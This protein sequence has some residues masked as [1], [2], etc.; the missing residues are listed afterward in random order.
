MSSRSSSNRNSNNNSNS[1]NQQNANF[2]SGNYSKNSPFFKNGKLLIIN[3]TD[4]KWKAVILN[5]PNKAQFLRGRHLGDG[6]AIKVSWKENG[7][8]YTH[9]YTKKTVA[10]L[11]GVRNIENWKVQRAIK[12][13]YSTRPELTVFR[14][15]TTRRW[16]KRRDIDF[17]ILKKTPATRRKLAANAAN[18]RATAFRTRGIPASKRKSK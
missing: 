8:N 9:Y 10:R 7:K 1:N 13:L 14:H 15:P 2:N 6:R 12:M 5:N 18:K 17:V 11:L 16:V 3:F 4:I